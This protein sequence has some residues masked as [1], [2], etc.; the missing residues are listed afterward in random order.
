MYFSA[1][2]RVKRLKLSLD[3]GCFEPPLVDEYRDVHVISSTL[4]LY[5]RELPE[6]LLTTTLYKEWMN[7]VGPHKTEEQRLNAV[8]EVLRKL[9]TSNHE[10]L[11]YLIQFLSKLS[12]HPENKMSSL[13]IA[14]CIAP[15]LLWNNE[16]EI[17]LHMNNCSIVN[18]I[19]ETF[20]AHADVLFPEDLTTC[21]RLSIGELLGE[22]EHEFVRPVVHGLKNKSDHEMG[23]DNDS[24][25]E[26][27]SPKPQTRNK[28]KAAAPIPPSM[29]QKSETDFVSI[30]RASLTAS[31]PS[32]STTLTRIKPRNDGSPKMKT[33][34][35]VNTD[36]ISVRR[37][38]LVGDENN[39]VKNESPKAILVNDDAKSAE[40]KGMEDLSK[41]HDF[42]FCRL[43]FHNDPKLQ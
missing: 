43:G 1:N 35:G 8:K 24:Y 26:S 32:G 7:C 41:L 14:I 9:P 21:N 17:N 27:S 25:G 37:R 3:S 13:N 5:L 30:D 2:S 23:H 4:K 36:E 18:M 40:A 29:M 39:A 6:P 28:K 34:V 31:Y 15:N 42:G 20:I 12:K 10:N 22:H 19:V 16:E 33:S 38:S 11:T